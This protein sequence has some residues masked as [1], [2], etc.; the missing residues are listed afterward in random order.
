MAQ[1]IVF[2]TIL[3]Y[4]KVII[5]EKLRTNFDTKYYRTLK[6]LLNCNNE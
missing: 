4:R 1:N 2:E 5:L 6:Q 3:S